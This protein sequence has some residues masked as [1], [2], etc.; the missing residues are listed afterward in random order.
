MGVPTPTS[1]SS[2]NIPTLPLYRAHGPVTPLLAAVTCERDQRPYTVWGGQGSVNGC[3][4]GGGGRNGPVEDVDEGLST[5]TTG[6]YWETVSVKD[7][8]GVVYSL[9]GLGSCTVR[10]LFIRN[11]FPSVVTP[12][13]S[14]LS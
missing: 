1:T 2:P 9:V 6:E 14:V 8:Y 7:V 11:S 12:L 13:V 5:D 3:Q 10:W 4:N